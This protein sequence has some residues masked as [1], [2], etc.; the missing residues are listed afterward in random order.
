MSKKQLTFT[1]RRERLEALAS[2]AEVIATDLAKYANALFESARV[3]G[4]ETESMKRAEARFAERTKSKK[5]TS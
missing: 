5:A 2:D 3:L 1:D 4:E